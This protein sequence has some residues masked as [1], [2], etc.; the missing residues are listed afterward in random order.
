MN[1]YCRKFTSI[2][3]CK[4]LKF[5][6]GSKVPPQNSDFREKRRGRRRRAKEYYLSSAFVYA[7]MC[8]LVCEEMLHKKRAYQLATE[9]NTTA[10]DKKFRSLKFNFFLYFSVFWN[11]FSFFESQQLMGHAHILVLVFYVVTKCQI[12]SVLH[13]Y[14]H[15]F[16]HIVFYLSFIFLERLCVTIKQ[17]IAQDFLCLS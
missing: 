2:E 16:F 6:K 5:L 8:C 17:H 10:Q 1:L 9:N 13:I 4:R 14:I 15:K 3:K 12:N 11:F 7:C